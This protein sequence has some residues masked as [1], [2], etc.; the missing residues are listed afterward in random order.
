[1]CSISPMPRRSAFGPAVA[2]AGREPGVPQVGGLDDVVVDADDLGERRGAAEPRGGVVDQIG[3][4]CSSVAANG[5]SGASDSSSA[6]TR[7]LVAGPD[8]QHDLGDTEAGVVLE[9]ALVGD[10]PEGDDARARPGRVRPAS[11]SARRRGHGLGQAA[12][13]DGD[14]AVGAARP[15]R[16]RPRRWRRRRPACARGAAAPAWAR[17]RSARSRRTRRGTR[18]GRS[19]RWPPWRA[20]CSRTTAWRRA[21]STPWSSASARFQPKPDAER[22]PAAR[23]MVERGH[24]LGQEDRV[25]LGGEQDAGAEPDPR[26]HRGRR[27]QRDERVE[28]ALVVVEAHALD[29]RGRRV[30][31]HRAGG[32]A[33]AGR[34][35]RSRAPRPPTASAAGARSRS[36]SAAVMPRRTV[37]T[38]GAWRRTRPGCRL[39]PRRRAARRTRPARGGWPRARR[40]AGRPA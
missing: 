28:A 37:R 15:R 7:P 23:E 4:G 18:P 5:T 11:A 1:M 8:A 14:P 24:L 13:A 40:R 25:V 6:R 12:A 32:C 21:K 3:H 26:R 2:E 20:R 19:T 29:Q 30:L 34:A 31:A 10:G 33:R 38:G 39:R 27:G 22:D 16:R 9:L 36:V 35:S 17:T